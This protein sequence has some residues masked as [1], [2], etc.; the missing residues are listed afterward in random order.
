MS[1]LDSVI[2]YAK[3][4]YSSYKDEEEV[5]MEAEVLMAIIKCKSH[6][7]EGRVSTQTVTIEFNLD[8]STNE[9]LK[10]ITVGRVIKRLGFRSKRTAEGLSGF[11]YD[12][13]VINRLRKRYNV[14]E[15]KQGKIV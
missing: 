3:D 5:S 12:A 11:V 15:T 2:A 10:S 13:N 7:R 8:R 14:L 1:V 9:A 4:S 6:V